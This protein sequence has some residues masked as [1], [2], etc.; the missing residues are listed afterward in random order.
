M[1]ESTQ[2]PI[3]QTENEDLDLQQAMA[4]GRVILNIVNMITTR[5]IMPAKLRGADPRITIGALID[6]AHVLSL[7][8]AG[9]NENEKKALRDHLTFVLAGTIEDVTSGT[10]PLSYI[11]ATHNGEKIS[12][13]CDFQDVFADQATFMKASGQIVG[14][15]N[16]EQVSLYSNLVQEEARELAEASEAYEQSPNRAEAEHLAKEACDVIVVA[17]GV[18]HS[19]GFNPG[20]AWLRVMGS[21]LSKIDPETQTVLKREDGKVLKGPNFKPANLSDLEW[22]TVNVPVQQ[23]ETT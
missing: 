6:A 5:V 12:F 4:M 16:E 1:T 15:E 3:D 23:S 14:T 22:T 8:A 21:N 9:D 2:E 20:E 7:V 18:L 11:H 13:K 17:A 10:P 19:L